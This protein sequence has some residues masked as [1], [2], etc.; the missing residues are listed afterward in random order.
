MPIERR[1]VRTY[2]WDRARRILLVFI[3]ALYPMK[4]VLAAL[5]IAGGRATGWLDLPPLISLLPW[6]LLALGSVVL[7]TTL[8]HLWFLYYLFWI[9]ILALALRWLMQRVLTQREPALDRVNRRFESMIAGRFGVFVA[10]LVLTPFL[11]MMDGLDVDTPDRSFAWNLPVMAVFGLWFAFGWW[12]F[13]H[14]SWL[15]VAARRWRAVLMLGVLTSLVGSG[16]AAIRVIAGPWA[17]AHADVLRWA[18]SFATSLTMTLSVTG[19][20]GLFVARGDRSSRPVRYLA[21]ARYFVYIAH[22][23]VVVAL[24]VWWVHAALPWW[25]QV[26]FVNAV[27]LAVL[28]AAYRRLVR[29]RGSAPG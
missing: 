5:W 21:D 6:Y 14:Q 17:T 11:A 27:T 22:L 16:L 18:A 29:F 24:Q 7:E 20:T 25:I 26:P 3:V 23:P 10:A 1:G 4:F 28:L 2:V 19:W 9:T 8:T 15:Q 13:R 12:L